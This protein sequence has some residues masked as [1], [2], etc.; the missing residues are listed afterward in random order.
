MTETK[1]VLIQLAFIDHLG[2]TNEKR[3]FFASSSKTF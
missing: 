2:K 3:V 1:F